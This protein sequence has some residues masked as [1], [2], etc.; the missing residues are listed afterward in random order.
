MWTVVVNCGEFVLVNNVVVIVVTVKRP[1]PPP[2]SR[3]PMRP[4]MNPNAKKQQRKVQF[5]A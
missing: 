5:V 1:Q 3:Q 2:N 4:H